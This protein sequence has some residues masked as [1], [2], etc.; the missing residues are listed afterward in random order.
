MISP[1]LRQTVQA[2]A[3][4]ATFPV[5]RTY[6]AQ[7]QRDELTDAEFLELAALY[8]DVWKQRVD[9]LLIAEKQSPGRMKN[10]RNK[11]SR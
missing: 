8:L 6:L 3:M 5:D 1:G 7:W 11:C 2:W 10:E 4:E 9:A